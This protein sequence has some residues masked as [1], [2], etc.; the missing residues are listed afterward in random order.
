MS[1]LSKSVIGSLVLSS[2][3]VSVV[4]LSGAVAH[5]ATTSHVLNH[6][7][8]NGSLES[9][10]VALVETNSRTKKIKVSIVNDICGQYSSGGGP[11]CM[12]ASA[13]VRSFE[14]PF[15]D[16]R[17]ACNS[18]VYQARRDLRPA[19]GEL[20]EISLTDSTQRT[21]DDLVMELPGIYVLTVNVDS[22]RGNPVRF[23]AYDKAQPSRD[24]GAIYESLNVE[25]EVLNPG[26]TGSS[27]TRKSVGGLVCE[28]ST[29]VVP[30]S[31][32]SYS[33]SLAQ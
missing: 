25:E 22:L 12:A 14:L 7:E 19:N 15:T 23:L 27:R 17:D 1:F 6:V 13:L 20:T 10:F 18:K 3:M 30:G 8:M 2:M 9:S 29:I 33:C 24:D 26:I 31:M 28:K 21:C 16:S 32:P 4:S 11:R 5:G